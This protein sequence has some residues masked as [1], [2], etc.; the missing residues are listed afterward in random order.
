MADP[1]AGALHRGPTGHRPPP[2]PSDLVAPAA[3]PE[4]TRLA[5]GRRPHISTK[6]YYWS[7]QA[8][9]GS[10][11]AARA[12][13]RRLDELSPG[14]AI[15]RY[16]V[17]AYLGG[18]GMGHVYRARDATLDRLIAIKVVRPSLADARAQQRLLDEARAMARIRHPAV[19]PVFDVGEF[20]GGIYV[21]MQFLTGGTLHAWIHAG[22]RPWRDVVAKFIP[23]GRGLS[24]AH[25]AGIIHR[26]VKPHNIL[27]DEHGAPLLTD[28][29]IAAD[30]DSGTDT[31]TRA[32]GT[33][34]YMP[35]EQ[36]AGRTVDARADQFAFCV[37]LWEGTQ[38]ERPQEAE[39]R[40]QGSGWLPT[41]ELHARRRVPRWLSIIISRGLSAA[42]DDRWPSMAALVDAL[43]RGLRRRRKLVL[44]TMAALC[45]VAV[46]AV[47]LA[48][49]QR[50]SPSKCDGGADDLT[51]AWSNAT[52]SR[53]AWRLT[54][55]PG[56]YASESTPAVLAALDA[57]ATRWIGIR[58]A[59]CVATSGGELPAVAADRRGACLAQARVALATV[60][61]F[62]EAVSAD[63]VAD[64]VNA[65]GT[66]PPIVACED[67]VGLATDIAPPAASQTEEVRAIE[68]LLARAAAEESAADL[69]AAE[70]HTDE[71]L[72]L[73]RRLGYQPLVARAL[74]AHGKII[75]TRRTA[76]G[77]TD[78]FDQA[79]YLA[80]EVGD[81]SLAIEAFARGV[82]AKATLGE[83]AQAD[84]GAA[85][86]EALAKRE[87]PRAAFARPLLQYMLG[88]AELARGQ[89][90]RARARFEVARAEL[91]DVNAGASGEL[92][93]VLQG[94]LLAATSDAER[95][96]LGA[97][98][99]ARR[100]RLLGPRHPRTLEAEYVAGAAL[101]DVKR[102]RV[103]IQKPCALLG[104]LHP[105]ETALIAE[106]SYEILW[107]SLV[108]D[109]QGDAIQA[110]ERVV[111]LEGPF[112]T[113]RLLARAFLALA[114]NQLDAADALLGKI[115]V[116]SPSAPWWF[117]LNN[118]DTMIGKALLARARG[119]ATV[120]DQWLNAAAE[121]ARRELPHS[122]TFGHRLTAIAWLLSTP[123]PT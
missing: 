38:G 68:G 116:A 50:A 9:D 39:T 89:R 19:V 113:R 33:P 54:S 22:P 102:G 16:V 65:V 91:P 1:L 93:V 14:T 3:V 88:T 29:G 25:A 31:G 49:P 96:E 92:V 24:T 18:G 44:A 23:I 2:G 100:G 114:N 80:I 123:A 41:S 42:V 58:N 69:E 43:E 115:D 26:D 47:L 37:S 35:P 28:F 6:G 98:L 81:N 59:T 94:Q 82:N 101:S 109:F 84:A 45:T 60:A 12:S 79:T 75:V 32:Y 117:Q 70:A 111:P 108:W 63:R 4:G 110:G 51:T 103:T 107:R 55:L 56:D 57:Y 104:D 17:E 36:A 73:A 52:R 13:T 27:L 15:G 72:R 76:N 64:L 66:L 99:V 78:V 120:R 85:F 20:E 48:R 97:E 121:L 40:T 105:A 61:S 34:A 30:V 10:H 67:D 112:P 122:L 86:F 62:A 90:D 7:R 53:V 71:A 77:H 83:I 5:L 87:G 95:E 8:M 11:P 118:V 106:C 119:I 74:V 21:A 46:V